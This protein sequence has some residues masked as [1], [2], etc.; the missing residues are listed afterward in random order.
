MRFARIP[1]AALG[2]CLLARLVLGQIPSPTGS[3]Y[4]TALDEQ[5]KILPGVVVTLVGPGAARTTSTD[6]RGDF[7][8]LQISPGSYALTLELDGFQTAAREAIVELGKNTVL[9]IEMAVAGAKEFVIVGAEAP[10]LDNRKIETGA[11]Y[12]RKELD[13]IPTTRDPWAIVRQ[14]PGV[15]VATMNVGGGESATQATFIGKGAHQDQNTY[16]LDGAAVTDMT[17]NGY[18]PIYFDFDSFNS[19]EI[20]TGGTDPSLSSPGVTINLVTKRG[21]N[22]PHG[23]GRALYA[24]TSGWDYGVEAGGPL[25]KDH[26]W[27][28]GAAARNAYAEQTFVT[29]SGQP[30]QGQATI[31]PYNAKL[32]AQLGGSNSLTLFYMNFNKIYDGRG[33]G[34]SRSQPATWN[35]TLPTSVYRAEDSQVVSTQLFASVNFSY[36]SNRFTLTPQGGLDQQ[37]DWDENEV[38]QNS[39]AYSTSRH[40]QHQMGATVSGFL[41]TGAL[42]HELKFGFGYKHYRADSAS[43]WPGGGI[44][45]LTP[46]GL[47][48]VTRASDASYEM[49]YYDTFL[50]DTVQAGNLTL[51]VGLR[52]DY[53]Q[54]KN[55]PSA[56]PANPLFPA[57]LPAVQYGGDAGYPITWRQFEPRVGA[58]Y[59]LG[60][61][62]STL[63]R[64]SYSRF[65]NQLGPDVVQV[66]A[67]PGIAYIYYGWNDAN[68]NGR[69]EPDE[70]DT[71]D[72]EGFAN[73]DPNNP[74]SSAPVNRIARDLKPP[75]TDEFIVGID[76][77]V[78]T[79]LA[80]SAAYTHRSVRNLE[81][82]PLIGTTTADFEY[83]GNVAGTALLSD[84]S[85]LDFSEPYYG[86]TT[87]P[88]PVGTEL[89]NR[90]DTRETYDGVELQVVK[91]LSHGWM[92]RASF[93]YND[94]RQ[95]IGPGA[96]VD[97]NGVVPNPNVSGPVVEQT[98]DRFGP[99]FV[100]S[101]WQFN[102]SGMVELPLG[103]E[104][105]AN[106]FGRQGFPLV[107]FVRTFANDTR[108]TILGVQ[109]GPTVSQRLSDVFELDLHAER[110]FRIGSTLTV[111][112]AIDCFNA[113]DSRTVLSRSGNAGTYNAARGTPFRP[114]TDENGDPTFHQPS[115]LLNSRVF[116]GGVRISF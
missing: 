88:P 73:V 96:I 38:W 100:N 49:N 69:V 101:T 108:D 58:T 111:T 112:P 33:A 7:H 54:G 102:V 97:P 63:L 82:A 55:L 20:A 56:V 17:N 64:A 80:I 25:W 60:S 35:Q 48:G 92:L 53:Q 51:N 91:R 72:L 65:V 14:V 42:R 43:A 18:T 10:L 34:P 90:P 27:L 83:L 28:W 32:D 21:T 103:I 12:D 110:A 78:S 41:D 47:A 89:R 9:S 93:A 39:Y 84:G 62:K 19:I 81:F 98:G 8:F 113:A 79:D 95:H 99:I 107:S 85:T 77:S 5:G 59:A 86:L 26:L 87:D 44:A 76:R 114:S 115:E 4:G 2:A 75:T 68:G 94:W 104:T 3:L 67:F 24:S 74:A 46:F 22:E 109:I 6:A 11:T 105:S 23:S 13:T 71:S 29:D 15:L 61:D 36:L 31:E 106:F 16:N 57:Q 52:F 66:N 70:V 45:A 40:P 37:A 1:V 116:R 50:G 30:V